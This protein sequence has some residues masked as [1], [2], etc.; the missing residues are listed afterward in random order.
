MIGEGMDL[1]RF[2]VWIP[3]EFLSFFADMELQRKVWVS[4]EF[5]EAWYDTLRVRIPGR[6]G[7]Y[8]ELV[9]RIERCHPFGIF[10]RLDL[11]TAREEAKQAE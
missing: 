5:L 8:R 6:I 3:A 9:F 2:N 4:R 11:G 10:R 1:D 7:A